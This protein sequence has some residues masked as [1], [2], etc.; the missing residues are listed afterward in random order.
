LYGVLDGSY[1]LSHCRM[2][3]GEWSWNS[4]AGEKM[5]EKISDKTFGKVALE[6]GFITKDQLD[7]ALRIQ[8]GEDVSK[9]SHRP[10]GRI[11]LNNGFI[12]FQQVGD[13]L[14]SMDKLYEEKTDKNFGDIAMEKGFITKDQLDSALRIQTD[15][16][17]I[18]GNRRSIGRILLNEGLITI[19]QIGEVLKSRDKRP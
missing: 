12:T 6:R 11:L 10:I 15:E 4:I 1:I 18:T 8:A 13:V 9:M 3:E 17:S 5:N 14:K 19:Q 2:N 7:E 16:Y